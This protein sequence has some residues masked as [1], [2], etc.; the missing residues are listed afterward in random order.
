MIRRKNPFKEN[1]VTEF[2]SENSKI[3]R[4]DGRDNYV[5]K[6]ILENVS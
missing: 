5:L 6:E 2:Q 3:I 1:F 4:M